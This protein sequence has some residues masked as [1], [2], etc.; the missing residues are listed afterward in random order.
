M[1]EKFL[2]LR[3]VILVRLFLW[4]GRNMMRTVLYKKFDQPGIVRISVKDHFP[5][6]VWCRENQSMY[7]LVSRQEQCKIDII[8]FPEFSRN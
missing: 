8:K 7:C 1:I 6:S 5:L 4:W 2:N 3:I